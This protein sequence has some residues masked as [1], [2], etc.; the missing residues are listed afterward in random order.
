M[1]EDNQKVYYGIRSDV[2]KI[3]AMVCMA[4]D[5]FGSF[6]VER[7]CKAIDLSTQ[8]GI[9]LYENVKLINTF[10]RE[11]G[12]LAFPIFCY[13]L[14]VGFYKT[15]SRKKYFLK[16]LTFAFIS[17]PFFDLANSNVL[18]EFREY[19][20]VFFTLS[21]G[22]LAIWLIDT[23]ENS[24]RN[25]KYSI[26]C[27]GAITVAACLLGSVLK[28]DY[29]FAGVFLIIV[30]YKLYGNRMQMV[31]YSPVLFLM[32]YAVRKYIQY[33]HNL[34]IVKESLISELPMAFAF[35]LIVQDNGVRK[36][37]KK[38]KWFG[39][40]FYPAHIFILYLIGRYI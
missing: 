9:D 15:S 12:R 3:V 20:N 22:F 27:Q 33:G 40:A 31:L 8:S 23:V 32:A 38:F 30:I 14:I 10:L 18:L 37:G 7:Y 17:E 11:I 25:E 24:I 34:H 19:Q 36:F 16:L 29:N 13:Q 2:L 6:V 1:N 4:I 35:M 21:I 39:Y 26:L 5:H 28:T